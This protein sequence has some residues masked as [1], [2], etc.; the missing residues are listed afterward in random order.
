MRPKAEEAPLASGFCSRSCRAAYF[1][2]PAVCMLWDSNI[3]LRSEWKARDKGPGRA[4][5]CMVCETAFDKRDAWELHALKAHTCFPIAESHAPS[6][7]MAK[8][9]RG[10]GHEDLSSDDD[11]ND[12]V[13]EAR[14]APLERVERCG[15]SVW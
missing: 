11:A 7:R 9:T 14:H 13:Y 10:V 12:H 6:F 4:Y 5:V 15:Y 3:P 1:L 8:P 2:E